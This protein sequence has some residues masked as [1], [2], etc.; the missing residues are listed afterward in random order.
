MKESTTKRCGKCKE[1]K[2]RAFFS[3]N[4]ARGDGL[5]PRCRV[6]LNA[7][8]RASHTPCPALGSEVLAC[9]ASHSEPQPMTTLRAL[10]PDLP[11]RAFYVPLASFIKRG[12]VVRSVIEGVAHFAIGRMPARAEAKPKPT[13][14]PK[15]KAFTLKQRSVLPVQN[16]EARQ[17]DHAARKGERVDAAQAI[18]N[19]EHG[20]VNRPV[21]K[22]APSSSAF[23]DANPDK[24]ERVPSSGPLAVSPASRFK[25]L[26]VIA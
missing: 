23:I 4:K 26:Q 14:K 1:H 16:K 6:C 19:R 7:A 11:A 10:R 12:H 17:R 2:P 24:F 20:V 8:K 9:L 21:A 3:S 5:E 25:H 13:P 22:A 18:R 15:P